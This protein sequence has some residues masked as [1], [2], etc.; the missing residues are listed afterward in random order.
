MPRV[1]VDFWDPVEL[2]GAPVDLLPLL[3]D[4]GDLPPVARICDRGP[5]ADYLAESSVSGSRGQGLAVRIRKENLPGKGNF[6]TGDL[7]SLALAAEEGI[8]EQVSF[9]YD[10][11]LQ[12]LVTQ[13]HRMFRASSVTRLLGEVAGHPFSVQPKLRQDAWNRLEGMTHIGSFELKMK[14]PVHH[15]DFSDSIPSMGQFL[16]DAGESLGALEVNLTLSVGRSRKK[17][18]N[19]GLI[20]LILAPFSSSLD[21][22]S[23]LKVRGKRTDD[24]PSEIVD[25]I[26][27]RLVFTREVS[28]E[29]R[30]LNRTQCQQL[31]IQAIAEHR[32]YLESLQ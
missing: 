22:V 32:E 1:T 31:L 20:R 29:G 14:G 15:P 27:D 25:F 17:S 18:L 11:D 8:A 26:K 16:D 7:S 4:V 9:L 19:Q 5:H 23:Q 6:Q 21:N 24:D 28:Y 12:V 10:R 2:S 30:S 13:R 3:N